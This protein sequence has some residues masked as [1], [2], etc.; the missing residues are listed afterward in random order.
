VSKFFSKDWLIVALGLFV[1]FGIGLLVVFYLNEDHSVTSDLI[2]ER[3]YIRVGVD[4]P[5]F[6][7]TDLTNQTV[8]LKKLFGK[9]IILN[10]W[11]TWCGPCR[12]EM[13][14]LESF[15]QNRSENIEFLAINMQEKEQSVQKFAGELNLN[16]PIL[17]D[18]DAEVSTMYRIQGLPTTVILSSEGK[19]SAIHIGVISES[20]LIGYL[21]K[22]G[23]NDD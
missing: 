14:M 15:Y 21:E 1:G 13:P 23:I 18:L 7:L 5:D 19:I 22:M 4:A 12:I 9:P 6:S 17:L 16:F 20:Q 8:Q 10:F 2:Q 3:A 11:A